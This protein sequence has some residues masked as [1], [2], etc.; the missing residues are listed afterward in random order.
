MTI[1]EE[2]PRILVCRGG[3]TGDFMLTT[4][5]FCSLRDRW[6]GAHIVLACRRNVAVLAI[7]AGLA[8][9]T[10]DIERPDISRLFATGAEC[11]AGWAEFIRSFDIILSYINDPE[12]IVCGNLRSIGAARIVSGSPI[13]T[14]GHAADFLMRP[15]AELGIV[16]GAPVVPRLKL[17][18]SY[19]HGGRS[20]LY[21]V[22]GGEKQAFHSCGSA[23]RV[24]PLLAEE[25]HAGS[26]A[27]EPQLSGEDSGCGLSQMRCADVVVIHPGSGSQKKNWPPVKYAELA[28]H[29]E[30]KMARKAVFLFGEADDLCRGVLGAGHGISA[31]SG[32]E[33]V[34]IAALISS[35]GAYVGND[36][37]ITHLAAALGVRT[38]ALF[39]PTDPEVWGPRGP[40]V[41][42]INAPE[43][44]LES[45]TAI[46]E[47]TVLD[48]LKQIFIKI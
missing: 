36:S 39:G 13:V 31:I 44:T 42:I 27:P 4:P 5:V 3:A 10:I 40:N 20:R 8:D 25:E 24:P 34:E 16:A 18:D 19:L 35:C 12:G 22:I 14:G 30:D 11:D 17:S 47:E 37:G 45:M 1:R 2:K 41:R 43:P 46:S 32:L 28:R 21:C 9:E 7:A 48:A 26:R 29:V 38:V 6:P 15:L 23:T 33:L